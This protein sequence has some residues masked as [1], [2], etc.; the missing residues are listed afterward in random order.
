MATDRTAALV[1]AWRRWD[2][3]PG[4]DSRAGA[5]EDECK[6]LAA[7]LGV[8]TSRLR[9]VL[10]DRRRAGDGYLPAIRAAITLLGPP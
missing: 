3:Y 7:D 8:S 9:D 5:F 2:E 6:L 10:N 1:E 4:Q